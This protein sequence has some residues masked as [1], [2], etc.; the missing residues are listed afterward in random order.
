MMPQAGMRFMVLPLMVKRRYAELK[1][2]AAHRDEIVYDG[3]DKDDP[4]RIDSEMADI[5]RKY[6][7]IMPGYKPT[8][9]YLTDFSGLSG[10]IHVLSETGLI[11]GAV[12]V[13]EGEAT[14]SLALFSSIPYAV[15]II[16]RAG[17][18]LAAFMAAQ[19]KGLPSALR[20]GHPFWFSEKVQVNDLFV[21]GE[22]ELC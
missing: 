5:E 13:F 6:P 21:Q 14:P 19:C 11:I 3:Q 7:I 20:Q 10:E 17:K 22:N 4:N 9:E 12:S 15:R 2:L 1:V 8:V 18:P 16:D